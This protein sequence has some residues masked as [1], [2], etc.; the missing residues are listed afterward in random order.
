LIALAVVLP[1]VLAAWQASR[2]AHDLLQWAREI[3]RSGLPAPAWLARL[4]F[5]AE[6][7]ANWWRE[8]LSEPGDPSELLR[9][10]TR[11]SLLVFTR[12]LGVQLIHRIVLF[13]FTIFALFF[14]FR[15]G[16]ALRAQMLAAS[17]HLFGPRGERV[18]RHMVASVHGTVNG[19][20]LVGL[21]EG[22]VL[23][24][25]YVVAG[26]PHPVLLGVLTAVAAMIPL[27]APLIFTIAALLLLAQGAA[28]AAA[29]IVGLGLVVV[30]IADHFI[31]PLLIGGATRLPFLWVL[32]GILGGV[33]TWGLFGL[34]LG[35]ALMAALVL[36]WRELIAE[37]ADP[38]LPPET[39]TPPVP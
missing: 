29:V 19:L 34:F 4:P 9:Q 14:I 2:E 16:R 10:F 36:L 23:G 1:L 30:G 3:E 38:P 26:V 25:A 28:L 35:P 33:E 8:N 13:A 18:A 11:G 5:G 37:T 31:R 32:L 24:I 6:Q 17:H 27:G 7:A 22:L 39:P 12:E 15:D 21:G 20:V